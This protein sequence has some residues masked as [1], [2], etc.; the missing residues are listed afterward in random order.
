[1]G[2]V[3][4]FIIVLTN[5][6]QS[7]GFDMNMMERGDYEYGKKE[8]KKDERRMDFVVSNRE[9]RVYYSLVVCIFIGERGFAL[10]FNILPFQ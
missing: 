5:E 7:N 4:L 6:M 1:M 10:L 8:V 9:L 2:E 3:T